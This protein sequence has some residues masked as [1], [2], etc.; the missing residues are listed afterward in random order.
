ME[1]NKK[2]MMVLTINTTDYEATIEVA[3][4]AGL[5]GV[6]SAMHNALQL[7]TFTYVT[8]LQ[9]LRGENDVHSSSS[10]YIY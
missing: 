8:E 3:Q 5:V 7:A 1:T 2:P 10:E 9:A 6:L 4:Q